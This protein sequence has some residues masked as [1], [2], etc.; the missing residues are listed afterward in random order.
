[1]GNIMT[2]ATSNVP[3]LPASQLAICSITQ[4]ATMKPSGGAMAAKITKRFME[5][6][7]WLPTLPGP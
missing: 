2:C 6:S 1:V 3:G 5:A 4:N 7:P